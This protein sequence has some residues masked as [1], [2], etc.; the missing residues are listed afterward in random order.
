NFSIDGGVLKKIGLK[1]GGSLETSQTQ[2][3]QRTF[4]QGN[5]DLGSVIV[6]FADNIIISQNFIKYLTREY[7]TGW[8]S[9]SVEPIRVQ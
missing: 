9:I 2:T 7:S 5:D 3:Y 8:Y 1:L 6:N 4:T